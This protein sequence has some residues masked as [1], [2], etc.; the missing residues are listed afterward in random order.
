MVT[1]TIEERLMALEA[2][3]AQLTGDETKA[4]GASSLVGADC[5]DVPGQ[6]GV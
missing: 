3:V 6:P 2:K 5:G 1:A 4:P